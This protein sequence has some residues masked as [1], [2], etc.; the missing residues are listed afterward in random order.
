[1]LSLSEILKLPFASFPNK[2]TKQKHQGSKQKREE[3]SQQ[4][5]LVGYKR[6]LGFLYKVIP[7]GNVFFEFLTKYFVG[8]L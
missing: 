8:C 6:K 4:R 2:K 1:L 7:H 3:E 5:K